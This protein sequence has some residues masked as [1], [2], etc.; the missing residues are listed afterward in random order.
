MD[1]QTIES[2]IDDVKQV[3][4]RQT[5]EYQNAILKDKKDEAQAQGE[6]K[7][8]TENKRLREE[9]LEGKAKETV[10]QINRLE[11]VMTV[12]EAAKFDAQRRAAQQLQVAEAWKDR[13]YG[14]AK[15]SDTMKIPEKN[16]GM[17]TTRSV[18]KIIVKRGEKYDRLKKDSNSKVN[19]KNLKTGNS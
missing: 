19:Y 8:E 9:E 6:K 10:E 3:S 12:V 17:K 14:R 11:K 13:M 5:I 7:L 2:L 15:K 16:S 18:F 4:Q 1:A